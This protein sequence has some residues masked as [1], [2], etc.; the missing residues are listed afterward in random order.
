LSDSTRPGEARRDS[1]LSLPRPSLEL[2]PR[3]GIAPA[4]PQDQLE[5][6]DRL[7]HGDPVEVV[8]V[9]VPDTQRAGGPVRGD[10]VD[11]VGR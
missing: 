11:S 1:L 7:V 9:A 10:I 3:F 5:V 6:R 2:L 4:G 8:D